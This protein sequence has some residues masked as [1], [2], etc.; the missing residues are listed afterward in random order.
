MTYVLLT[1]T[2]VEREK[3]EAY[4]GKHLAGEQDFFARYIADWERALSGQKQN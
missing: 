3:W 1:K 4:M 2:M